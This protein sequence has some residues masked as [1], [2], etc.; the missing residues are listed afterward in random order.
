MIRPQVLRHKHT[1]TSYYRLT[2]DFEHHL[3]LLLLLLLRSSATRLQTVTVSL[4][5]ELVVLNLSFR[6][7]SNSMFSLHLKD[8]IGVTDI[9]KISKMT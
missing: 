8:D 2:F 3:L 1:F 7:R 4:L 5:H 6:V 9:L